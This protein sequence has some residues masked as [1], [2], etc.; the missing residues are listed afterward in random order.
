MKPVG[1][2][3]RALLSF[4][5]RQSEYLAQQ[6]AQN[7]W[8]YRDLAE[9]LAQSVKETDQLLYFPGNLHLTKSGHEVV[10]REISYL[11]LSQ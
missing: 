6:S 7:G 11:L 3:K 9:A 5:Q 1:T 4:H 8:K 10:A 2:N